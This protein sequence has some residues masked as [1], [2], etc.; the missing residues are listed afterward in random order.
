VLVGPM[1]EITLYCFGV[2]DVEDP[3]LAVR[4]HVGEW[5]NSSERWKYCKQLTGSQFPPLSYDLDHD[6]SMDGG[7][8]CTIT[9]RLPSSCATLYQIRFPEPEMCYN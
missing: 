3:E 7:W 2:A 1:T 5:A 4:L 8:I 9:T 6:G